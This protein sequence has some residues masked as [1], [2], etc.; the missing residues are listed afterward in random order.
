MQQSLTIT[1]AG[2]GI[3]GLWQAIT[4]SRAGHKVRVLERHPV[5]FEKA[6]SQYAGAMIA[7]YCEAE[8]AEPIVRDLGL[9][10][11]RLWKETYPDL[12]RNGTLVVAGPRDQSELRRFAR[13]TV[14]HSTV[15]ADR[16]AE[17]EPD[18]A[19]RFTGGLFY[20]DEAHMATPAA[21]R[22]LLNL[23]RSAG[24]QFHFGTEWNGI[25][26]DESD[27]TIDCRGIAA[28]DELTS[29]R[30]VRGERLLIETDDISFSR[31]I[32]LLHPRFAS[33]I[34]PWGDGRFLVG[35]TVIESD[36]SRDMTVRSALELLGLAYALHPAFGEAQIV[37]LTAGVRPSFGD[38]I[39][40]VLAGKGGGQKIIRVNG[41]FRHGFLLAPVMA[42]IVAKHLGH[43]SFEHPLLVREVN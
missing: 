36:D 30:G 28:R 29:L 11:A 5:P 32:R 43:D 25:A 7:P 31:P 3:F 33:Y 41:A 16:V 38:N 9:D 40:R 15:N 22:D 8:S 34:V 21:L 14:G 6:A 24:A 17:L 13:L 27:W 35:A 2:A 26:E 12:K 20:S 1:I 37:E 19:G 18:L 10:A 23:A 39:P 42:D 4:L